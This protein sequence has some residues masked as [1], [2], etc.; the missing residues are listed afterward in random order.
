MTLTTEFRY[1]V[2]KSSETPYVSFFMQIYSPNNCLKK[3]NLNFIFSYKNLDS[4]VQYFIIFITKPSV[5]VFKK[6]NR[7]E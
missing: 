1:C 5:T 2:I 4:R 7:L 6:Q 3:F